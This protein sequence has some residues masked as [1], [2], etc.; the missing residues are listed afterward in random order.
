MIG[1]HEYVLDIERSF[2]KIVCHSEKAKVFMFPRKIFHTRF[3]NST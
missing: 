3:Q 1:I 2:T